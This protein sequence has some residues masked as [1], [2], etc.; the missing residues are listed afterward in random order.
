MNIYEAS[1]NM[2]DVSVD[3]IVDLGARHGESYELFGSKR[4][5]KNYVFVEPAS[6][7]HQHILNV[8][9]NAKDSERMFLLP[10]VLSDVE[11]NV[12]LY[13]FKSDFDQSS[14]LYSDRQNRYGTPTIEVV[15]QY[16]YKDVFKDQIIDF[17]K[18][19]IEGGEYHLIEIGFFNQVSSFVMEVHNGIVANRT[20]RDV[21][22]SLKDKFHLEIWGNTSYKYCYVNGKRKI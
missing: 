17:V 8:I 21:V 11:G 12:E 1:L 9:K 18:C 5:F 13:T 15:Q 19:N 14:N 4:Q 22:D 16:S 7:C 10:G 3:I 6:K 2:T 20:Y